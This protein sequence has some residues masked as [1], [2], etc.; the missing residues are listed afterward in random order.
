MLLEGVDVDLWEDGCRVLHWLIL[1]DLV[2][3]V[4]GVHNVLLVD[5][6]V[7]DRLDVLMNV[8]VDVLACNSWSRFLNMLRRADVA[9]VLKLASLPL[10]LTLDLVVTT[11]PDLPS[12]Y[13]SDLL[14]MSG[15]CGGLVADWL[16]G[17]MVVV[18]VD[19][20]VDD[21]L[22][23]VALGLRDVLVLDGWVDGLVDGGVCLA[24]A[25]K[26][27][28]DVLLDLLGWVHGGRGILGGV[29]GSLHLDS[30]FSVLLLQVFGFG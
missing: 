24:V 12:L 10:K 28:G 7:D 4:G 6:T 29:V 9:G 11:V 27:G 22:V 2:D 1:V 14:G 23:L 19:L 17:G 15:R 3:G 21:L 20:A 25:V 16:G 13:W 5:L 8:V 18:L 26:E 30:L